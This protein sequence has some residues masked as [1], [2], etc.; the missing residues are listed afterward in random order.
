MIV[1]SI[2]KSTLSVAVLLLMAS[3]SQESFT[4]QRDSNDKAEQEKGIY[5]RMTATQGATDTRVSHT[6]TKDNNEYSMLLAWDTDPAKEKLFVKGYPASGDIFAAGV[7]T[8]VERLSDKKMTFEGSNIQPAERYQFFYPY[9]GAEQDMSKLTFKG[10]IQDCNHPTEHL[11]KYDWMTTTNAITSMDESF[12][13]RHLSTLIRFDLT[14]PTGT[15]QSVNTITLKSDK[16]V[17]SLDYNF[18]EERKITP[19]NNF[20][21]TLQNDPADNV[22]IGYAMI[23][24]NQPET[25]KFQIVAT[26]NDNKTFIS[27]EFQSGSLSIGKLYT[28]KATLEETTTTD[29]TGDAPATEEECKAVLGTPVES[30]Y[31]LHSAYQLAAFTILVNLGNGTINGKLMGDM[32]LKNH[33]W[34]CMGTN[35]NPFKGVFDGQGH[36]ITGFY[37]QQTSPDDVASFIT[38]LAG[39]GVVQN[40]QVEGK[41]EVMI[42]ELVYSYSAG[43][44]G[45]TG[46]NTTVLFCSFS[47]TIQGPDPSIKAGGIVA[48]HYGTMRSCI[49]LATMIRGNTLVS[50][51]GG[52]AGVMEAGAGTSYSGW[53]LDRDAIRGVAKAFG[54]KENGAIDENN[55]SFSTLNTT[56]LNTINNDSGHTSEYIWTLNSS[57][58][59]R[60]S[61]RNP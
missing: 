1:K 16:N 58:E 20:H 57:N 56:F 40:L 59:L 46:K 29:W 44:V 48:V 36:R 15:N 49:G 7:L 39:A 22:A 50:P 53:L 38:E 6:E 3:C 28:I 41:I 30:F 27:K 24:F 8:G 23:L 4:E 31:E 33:Q 11:K 21:L 35:S 5:L 9:M 14:L 19:S 61:K 42:E 54:K 34:L 18:M 37:I 60:L 52:L 51:I 17:I 45:I 12:T 32:D 25:A 47:G 13:L 10:Q 26:T 43:I 55:S 2:L